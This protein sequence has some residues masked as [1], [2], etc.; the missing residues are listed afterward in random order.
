MR[1]SYQGTFLT[2]YLLRRDVR[3]AMES[4]SNAAAETLSFVGGF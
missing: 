1:S 3:G 2:D 4:G